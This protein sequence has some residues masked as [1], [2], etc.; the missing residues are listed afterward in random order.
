MTTCWVEN[1]SIEQVCHN[2]QQ[3]KWNRLVLQEAE[4]MGGN[5]T[6][7]GV[8]QDGVLTENY[9]TNDSNRYKESEGCEK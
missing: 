4:R 5:D 9:N 1:E 2:K 6:D 7:V 3:H 8:Y